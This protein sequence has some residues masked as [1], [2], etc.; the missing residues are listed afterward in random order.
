MYC[1]KCGAEMADNA[2]FCPDCGQPAGADTGFRCPRCQAAIRADTTLCPSCGLQMMPY[3]PAAAQQSGPSLKTAMT[4]IGVM[5]AAMVIAMGVFFH[6]MVQRVVQ[7]SREIQSV[8]E[9]AV[10]ATE[11]AS[12]RTG[13][14]ETVHYFPAEE[15][16]FPPAETVLG[17]VRAEYPTIGDFAW[18]ENFTSVPDDV[19]YLEAGEFD[20]NWKGM[21]VYDETTRSLLQAEIR[22]EP[23]DICVTL[24]WYQFWFNGE[25]PAADDAPDTVLS[26]SSQ[27]SGISAAGAG[28]LELT[29]FY[30][31]DGRQYAIGS[32]QPEGFAAGTIV[33]V[34]E[35]P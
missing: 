27:G 35:I 29:D 10:P 34:R 25:E 7:K 18:Y 20:G 19:R 33:L 28:T 32:F 8:T 22:T 2:K 3:T 16:E 13:E 1:Q 21:I 6:R 30:E 9:A 26:G 5:C 31:K 15:V 12:V 11:T 23:Q 24:D 14:V 17:S 4:V